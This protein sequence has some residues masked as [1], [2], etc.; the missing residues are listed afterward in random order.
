M[1]PNNVFSQKS[2]RI[3]NFWNKF[4]NPHIKPVLLAGTNI[5]Y[6]NF[7]LKCL[8]AHC[9]P[10][11]D[12]FEI[13]F[14]SAQGQSRRRH[15]RNCW[16]DRTICWVF[17]S[18]AGG[19]VITDLI[20]LCSWKFVFCILCDNSSN[21]DNSSTATSIDMQETTLS[22]NQP[23]GAQRNRKEQ[24]RNRREQP[25]NRC[26]WSETEEPQETESCEDN[27]DQKREVEATF[28]APLVDLEPLQI[29]TFLATVSWHWTEIKMILANTL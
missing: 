6:I 19:P 9:V 27:D 29:R 16:H 28:V 4:L 12:C 18:L 5:W 3:L 8:P 15:H 1:D 26:S 24:R 13:I 7:V 2:P 22:A 25:R 17:Y 20:S 10:K 21:S 23:L 11:E 14:I